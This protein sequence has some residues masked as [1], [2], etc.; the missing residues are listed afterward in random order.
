MH[1]DFIEWE[2]CDVLRETGMTV[3]AIKAVKGSRGGGTSC[4]E[5]KG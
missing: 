4:D 2:Y 3:K 5:E 1:E